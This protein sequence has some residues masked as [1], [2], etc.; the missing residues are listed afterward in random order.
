MQPFN[1][2]ETSSMA[3]RGE[4][5]D[6]WFPA[7]AKQSVSSP[8]LRLICF[9]SSGTMEAMYTQK[10]RGSDRKM[11]N[12]ELMKWAAAECVEVLAV[13]LPGRGKR[14][15]E[16][17]AQSLA[18]VAATL[19]PILEPV[20]ASSPACPW[21]VVGHSMGA[22]AAFELIKE[23]ERRGIV[24]P[25]SFLVAACF[26]APDLPLTERP[27]TPNRGMGEAAFKE[28]CRGWDI[29]DAV[30]ST[31]HIWQSF[32]AMIR[33]DFTL[34][35]EYP[36]SSSVLPC[37]VAAC[38]AAADKRVS[39]S[40]VEG[41]SRFGSSF[42]VLP[43][44]EGHHLFVLDDQLKA[45]W[46]S[47]TLIPALTARA[48]EVATPPAS[49]VAADAAAPSPPIVTSSLPLPPSLA[50]PPPVP[51]RVLCL[52]GF[53]GS[54]DILEKQTERL[55][56]LVAA[57]LAADSDPR[58]AAAKARSGDGMPLIEWEFLTSPVDVDWDP[59]A[60]EARLVTT[61][62]PGNPNRQW[63]RR[64]SVDAP[65][66][67]TILSSVDGS[68]TAGDGT[69]K[70]AGWEEPLDFVLEHLKASGPYF[71]VL[72]FSQ[73]ANLA[74]LLVALQEARVIPRAFEC[75]VL[76]CG[77]AF[78]W[79]KQWETAAAVNPS[80]RSDDL[81]FRSPLS[82][83]SLHLIGNADPLKPNSEALAELFQNATTAHFASGHKPPTQK[84]A[85]AALSSFLKGALPPEA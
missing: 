6:A 51:L 25:P 36:G 21:A 64:V 42:Q 30:L 17:F 26:P 55:R 70:Y 34:F 3:Q 43:Q 15:K 31:P 13:Q 67:P 48:F 52:H 73:G 37:A 56:T 5:F 24:P 9:A 12:N 47:S 76:V 8:R 35:D 27:W 33:S 11:G 16:P 50:S 78:G 60:F 44:C 72:G 82:T 57:D 80:W 69:Q 59:E 40:L 32:G 79:H 75:S 18:E 46:F 58:V 1:E 2:V 61:Y 81:L 23:V 63:M 62:F 85:A 38:G 7:A 71:A 49:P 83:P 68:L 45:A 77:S 84:A 65:D 20:I 4:T 29:N 39:S 41:W 22:W 10:V 54:A 53:G 74:S 19:A 66:G 14:H 28:E